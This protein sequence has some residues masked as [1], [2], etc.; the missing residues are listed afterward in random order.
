MHSRLVELELF[1]PFQ[2]GWLSQNSAIETWWL[3]C[4]LLTATKCFTVLLVSLACC[5]ISKALVVSFLMEASEQ[6]KH[7]KARSH[8]GFSGISL[9]DQLNHWQ[10]EIGTLSTNY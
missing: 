4:F 2:M 1:L 7:V 10:P 5:S 3:K 8:C 9:M 6:V